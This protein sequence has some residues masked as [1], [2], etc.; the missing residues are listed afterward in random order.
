MIYINDE[1]NATLSSILFTTTEVLRL[2][3]LSL[4]S[5]Q[6]IQ[7][8]ISLGIRDYSPSIYGLQTVNLVTNKAMTNVNVRTS[9]QRLQHQPHGLEA[10]I[11]V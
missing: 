4:V 10:L 1:T 6:F 7:K 8:L 5:F 2:L 3:V 11:T 9:S